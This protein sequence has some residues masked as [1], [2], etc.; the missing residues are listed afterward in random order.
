M[1][2]ASRAAKASETGSGILT[3]CALYSRLL[4]S[5]GR[6]HPISL[7]KTEVRMPGVEEPGIKSIAW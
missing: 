3:I 6:A 5:N 2:P 7:V 1:R 4:V